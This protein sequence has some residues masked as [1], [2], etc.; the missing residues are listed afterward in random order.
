MIRI[1]FKDIDNI[2]LFGGIYPGIDKGRFNEFYKFLYDYGIYKDFTD[3]F[4]RCNNIDWIIS[5]S[6]CQNNYDINEY[7]SNVDVRSYI[8]RAFNWHNNEGFRFWKRYS[9]MWEF[10]FLMG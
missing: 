5:N 3:N 9:D 4:Y 2:D 6:G 8:F 1:D 7:L 10:R